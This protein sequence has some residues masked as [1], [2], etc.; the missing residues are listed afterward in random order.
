M[1]IV[2]MVLSL[3][4]NA[5]LKSIKVFHDSKLIS[6]FPDFDFE[7]ISDNDDENFVDVPSDTSALS[8]Y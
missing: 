1:F 8:T 3:L 7:D 5:K 4:K 6:L 2:L